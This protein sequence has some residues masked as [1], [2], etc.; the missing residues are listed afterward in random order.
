M[1][2]G[3]QFLKNFFIHHMKFH[4]SNQINFSVHGAVESLAAL[5]VTR[6]DDNVGKAILLYALAGSLVDLLNDHN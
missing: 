3:N 6:L 2:R 4:T 1:Q 5:G